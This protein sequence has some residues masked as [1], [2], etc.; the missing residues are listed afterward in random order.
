MIV[1][2]NPGVTSALGC[3]LVDIRHDLS[4]MYSCL[5]SEADEEEFERGY[6]GLEHEA[7]CRLEQEGVQRSQALLQRNASMRYSGQWRSLVVDVGSG[8]GA[9]AEAVERFHEDHEREFA[10]RRDET[11]VEIYQLGLKATGITP[12][13][14]FAMHDFQTRQVAPKEERPVWFKEVGWSDTPVYERTDLGAGTTLDGPAIIDQLDSTT[15][16]PP[17]ARAEIDSW[18]NIRIHFKEA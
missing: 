4:T 1:P 14:A 12:K 5:A 9:L 16:V 6:H 13:P 8:P 7:M 10:F 11:P 3:L 17:R 15:V 18:L 2:A